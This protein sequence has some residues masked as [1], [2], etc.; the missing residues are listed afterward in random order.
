[1]TE[2]EIQRTLARRRQAGGYS[3]AELRAFEIE[4]REAYREGGVA[5]PTRRPHRKFRYC[6]RLFLPCRA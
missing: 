1:V 5:I 4:L 2:A 3:E 6:K